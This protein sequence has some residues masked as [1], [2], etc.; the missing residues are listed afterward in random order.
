MLLSV[1][2]RFE[3]LPTEEARH[4]RAHNLRQNIQADYDGMA[5]S[6]IQLAFSIKAFHMRQEAIQGPMSTKDM[7]KVYTEKARASG[8][9]NS[10]KDGFIDTCLTVWK[11]LL[12]DP[13]VRDELLKLEQLYGK[14]HHYHSHYRIGRYARVTA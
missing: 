3:M 8:S 12:T 2:C 11:H 6:D 13:H 7:I 14:R 5:R 1:S 10:M 4:F 9:S